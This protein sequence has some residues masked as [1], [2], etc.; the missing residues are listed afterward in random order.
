MTYSQCMLLLTLWTRIFIYL[1]GTFLIYKV[2]IW[3]MVGK[4]KISASVA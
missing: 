1:S 3:F 4:L 2:L